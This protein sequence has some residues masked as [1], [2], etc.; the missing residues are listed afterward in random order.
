MF[1]LFQGTT[2]NPKGA[3]LSHHNIVNNAFIFGLR[4]RFDT[5]VSPSRR[6]HQEAEKVSLLPS[7][8]FI[9]LSAQSAD[10]C[11]GASVPLFWLRVGRD[12]HGGAWRHSGLP[13]HCLQQ[14]SQPAG[15]PA[16]E[17]S[18]LNSANTS[19]CNLLTSLS[20]DQVQRGL[21]HSNNVHRHGQPGF[22]QV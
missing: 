6:L 9:L 3:T 5:R 16:G 19:T 13:L 18:A 11:A 22:A 14:R 17:V 12:D 7:Y 10:M 21:R 8:S 20:G 1:S 2:G 15:H 4:M